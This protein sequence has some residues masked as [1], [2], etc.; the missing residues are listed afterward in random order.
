MLCREQQLLNRRRSNHTPARGAKIQIEDDVW[1]LHLQPDLRIN[2]R[3]PNQVGLLSEGH[4]H[5]VEPPSEHIKH[6]SKNL[7]IVPAGP[8]RHMKGMI[9]IR[10]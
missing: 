4:S 3:L 1:A 2:R 5:I 7:R 10:K 9:G 6:L 8:C